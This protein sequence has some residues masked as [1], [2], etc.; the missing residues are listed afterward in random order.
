M[1]GEVFEMRGLATILFL[2]AFPLSNAAAQEQTPADPVTE[3]ANR[4]IADANAS[5]IFM[6]DISPEAPRPRVRHQA[7]GM[8]CTLSSQFTAARLRVVET[9]AP[10][11]DEVV[12]STSNE[13]IGQGIYLRRM[14]S[15]LTLEQDM[16]AFQSEVVGSRADF[17]V[18]TSAPALTAA[19]GVEEQT[20]ALGNGRTWSYL[21]VAHINGWSVRMRISAQ[22]GAVPL[23]I[24]QANR[25]WAATVQSLLEHTP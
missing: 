9:E 21:R 2:I 12:C 22:Q 4:Y 25:E 8:L 1:C 14:A 16:A 11:G 18:D 13:W 7:S 6:A 3:L 20:L 19:A 24:P 23:L 10:R 5:E 17:R 15:P